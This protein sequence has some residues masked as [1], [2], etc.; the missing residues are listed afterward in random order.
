MVRAAAGG[1]SYSRQGAAAAILARPGHRAAMALPAPASLRGEDDGTIAQTP[2]G[3]FLGC[4]G[5]LL[6]CTGWAELGCGQKERKR[7]REW[8][9][10]R[11]REER[12][13][14]PIFLFLVFISLFKTQFQICF[15]SCLKTQISREYIKHTW[16]Y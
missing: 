3:V 14:L 8:A 1:A 6:G 11:E 5:G 15:E 16:P 12:G 2:L 10:P 4:G 9:E 13:F 7:E